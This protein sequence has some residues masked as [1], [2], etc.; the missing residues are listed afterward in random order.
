[1]Y[2]TRIIQVDKIDADK[3]EQIFKKNQNT[4]EKNCEDPYKG[5][6]NAFLTPYDGKL[7]A[8]ITKDSTG[9][10]VG[11]TNGRVRGKA[12]H[13]TNVLVSQ[14]KA[15]ILSAESFHTVLKSLGIECIKG[16]VIKHTPMFTFLTQSMGRKD[17]FSAEPL[18]HNIEKH[19]GLIVQ[20]TLL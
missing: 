10:V 2:S 9:E 14:S 12:Y 11:Y 4:I 3:L 1:M 7:T 15:F 8:E 5:I 6:K 18:I 16:H 17:L 13:C 20:L 19:D